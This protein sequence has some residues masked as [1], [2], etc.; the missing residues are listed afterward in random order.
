MANIK[1]CIFDLD[2][3]IV[4]TA[5]YHYLA[6]KRLANELGFDFTEKDNEKLKG[7]SR[8]ESLEILLNLG[9]IKVDEETKLKLAE[10]KNNW[11]RE[12]IS[13]MDESEIL[14]RVKEFINEL[15]N[16]NIKVAI[17]SSSKNTMTILNSIKMTDFFDAIIDG[18]K[19]T[20]AKPDPEVFLLGAEAL[21]VNP[22]ECVVFEDAESGIKAAKN[23]G[24]Y[25]VGIGS[26]EIL[27]EADK[28][29]PNTNS[30]TLDIINF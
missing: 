30:L 10:K 6:W 19:I 21:G 4:D 17:G 20:K 8:M 29:I 24:M 12:L 23:A 13:K 7:V 14:P 2:G 15:K 26:N 5:K 3:V 16:S 9:N 27:K 18:N 25:A 1:A 11:Y 22:N 28:V